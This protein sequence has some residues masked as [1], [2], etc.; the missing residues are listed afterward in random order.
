MNFST[1][2][3]KR[4]TLQVAHSPMKK[5]GK[6]VVVFGSSTGISFYAPFTTS[7][8]SKLSFIMRSETGYGNTL[9]VCLSLCHDNFRIFQ[10]FFLQSS[11]EVKSEVKFINVLPK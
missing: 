4:V 2:K 8:I 11:I 6:L 7:K 9:S 3:S 5:T 10:H 1:F